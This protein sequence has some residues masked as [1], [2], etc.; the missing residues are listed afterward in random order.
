MTETEGVQ[1]VE[2]INLTDEVSPP[3]RAD[4]PPPP[5]SPPTLAWNDWDAL[6]RQSLFAHKTKSTSRNG[7][8]N[9]L[10]ES[11]SV[12]SASRDSKKEHSK[13]V[14]DLGLG[15][16]PVHM[17]SVSGLHIE[18]VYSKRGLGTGSVPQELPAGYIPELASESEHFTLFC[19]A[20][21]APSI[22]GGP[23]QG[24]LRRLCVRMKKPA[25]HLFIEDDG[26]YLGAAGT[27]RWVYG[28]KRPGQAELLP[29]QAVKTG[30]PPT[31]VAIVAHSVQ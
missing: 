29:A 25:T 4:A 20:G 1:D 15:P 12:L 26:C 7:V 27:R 3:P 10:P 5:R 18:E 31:S 14:T 8:E 6:N 16:L 22:A 24:H 2:T 9:L 17:F 30:A 13:S 21:T 23:H 11:C 19:N 28:Q